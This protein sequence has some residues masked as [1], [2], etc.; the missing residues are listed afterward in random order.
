MTFAETVQVAAQ[1]HNTRIIT[2][3]LCLAM[4]AGLFAWDWYCMYN[5]IIG[6]TVSEI[7]RQANYASGGL[8]ALGSLLLFLS[9]WIHIFLFQFLPNSWT[10]L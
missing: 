5:E 9:V 10:G 6:D 1:P 7:S 4:A 3:I 8:L 2:I